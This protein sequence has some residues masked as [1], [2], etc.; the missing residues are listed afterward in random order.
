MPIRISKH[1][2]YLD[3]RF[4]ELRLIKQSLLDTIDFHISGSKEDYD[5]ARVQQRASDGGANLGFS[6]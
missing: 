5:I 4:F 6:L 3:R 1:L 2:D